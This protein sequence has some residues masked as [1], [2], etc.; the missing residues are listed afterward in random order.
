MRTIPLSLLLSAACLLAA[1]QSPA[2]QT[3]T[4][5][6][7]SGETGMNATDPATTG[8]VEIHGRA[9]YLEKILVPEGS[10]L[11]VQLLDN[12]LADTPA[13]VIA[14]R[15]VSVGSGPYDFTLPVDAAKL[16]AGGSYGLH[17]GLTMPDGS[18]RFVTDTRVPVQP[19]AA[20]TVEFRLV[21]IQ[22]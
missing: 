15:E 18:L 8:T 12:Q 16:R 19:G 9:F 20:E 6:T 1:C 3:G 4:A 2:G 17:A 21:H 13:A 5:A 10:T 14:E 7:A 11:R 22:P